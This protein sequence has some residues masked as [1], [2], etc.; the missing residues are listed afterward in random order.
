MVVARV[1]AVAVIVLVVGGFCAMTVAGLER[2]ERA[3]AIAG[4]V[5]A[6]GTVLA[7]AAGFA[8]RRPRATTDWTDTDDA[9][10][11]DAGG[12]DD[13]GDADDGGDGGE[14]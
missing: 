14:A 4:G 9:A 2:G 11:A 12:A 1:V 6:A 5:L 7:L 3:T 10:D 13:C 8:P